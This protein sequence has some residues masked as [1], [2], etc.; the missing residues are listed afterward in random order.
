MLQVLKKSNGFVISSPEEVI[1]AE[2]REFRSEAGINCS[3]EAGVV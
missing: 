2:T 3:S 1:N